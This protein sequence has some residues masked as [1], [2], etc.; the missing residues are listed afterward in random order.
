MKRRHIV[1]WILLLFVLSACTAVTTVDPFPTIDPTLAASVKCV[2]ATEEAN[3]AAEAANCLIEPGAADSETP[4]AMLFATAVPI[5]PQ[6]NPTATPTT[7]PTATP[8]STP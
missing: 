7:T 2:A 5:A 6:L 8:T 4:A 1:V 3:A